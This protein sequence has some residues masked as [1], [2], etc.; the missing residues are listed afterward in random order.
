MICSLPRL[1]ATL[2]G[3][4]VALSLSAPAVA[5]WKIATV[6]APPSMLGLMVDRGAA[7]IG[8]A[9][10]DKIT[11]ERLQ[12]P[13]EQEIT[14]NL[15]KG[16]YEMAY[17]SATGIG[18]A[19]PEMGVLNTP[20]LWLSDKE[21]DY[22]S[23]KFVAPF[24][25]SLLASRGLVLVRYGEAGWTSLFCKVDC[26]TLAKVKGL[27]FR[28][29][30]TAAGKAFAG[31]IGVSP[32]PGLSLPD[33]FAALQKGDVD[34]G[35]LPFSFYMITPAAKLAPHF[36]FTRHSHQPAFWVANKAVW[37]KLSKAEQDQIAGALPSVSEVRVRLA[38]EEAKRT[39]LHK[40][41]GGFI[42]E[43]SD[44]ERAEWAQAV[45]PAHADLIKSY[46][47]RSKELFDLIQKGKKEFA[48]QKG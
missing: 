40:N 36:V 32:V 28:V 41:S 45:L 44:A 12:N 19:I 25:E 9:T 3:M 26:S 15:L 24:V 23:D 8:V 38:G 42:Y 48:A 17:V 14:Q 35:D 21:R 30:Q 22:V 39:Q 29:A 37:D 34:A 16:Q 10:G 46:G 2:S 1:A 11:A 5:Q 13:N 27:K 7:A 18:S 20:Y 33:F 43:L 6:A 31:H 47:G 4:V